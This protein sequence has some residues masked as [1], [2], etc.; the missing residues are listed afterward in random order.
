MQGKESRVTTGRIIVHQVVFRSQHELRER[1]AKQ[2]MVFRLLN[3]EPR[4]RR[5]AIE[6]AEQLA[7]HISANDAC[8]T[9]F[10][11]IGEQRICMLNACRLHIPKDA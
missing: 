8:I 5:D 3:P 6:D 7:S 10:A 11:S 2:S 1:L 9:A 4:I